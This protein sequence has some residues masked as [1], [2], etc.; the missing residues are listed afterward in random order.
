MLYRLP[1]APYSCKLDHFEDMKDNQNPRTHH[2][3]RSHRQVKGD[4]KLL[5]YAYYAIKKIQQLT[6]IKL[7]IP[8]RSR[9]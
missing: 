4:P 2:T 3:A 6:L 1:I 8:Y 7:T 9:N 5:L